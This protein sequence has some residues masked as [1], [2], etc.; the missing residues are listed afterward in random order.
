MP[1]ARFLWVKTL[2][3]SHA[4]QGLGIGGSAM[5]L[6]EAVSATPPLNARH[7][8]LDTLC[9]EDQL[10]EELAVAYFGQVPKVRL[11]VVEINAD[12]LC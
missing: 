11:F 12:R 10:N 6:A 1:T 4:L 3:V 5:K 7:L 9:A 8:L 2:Y